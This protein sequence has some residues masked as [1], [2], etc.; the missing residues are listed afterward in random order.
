MRKSNQHLMGTP[1]GET[2]E[3]RGKA[4]L[5]ELIK[6]TSLRLMKCMGLQLEPQNPQ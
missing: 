3:G 4:V 5:E 1:Q 6:E 2:T